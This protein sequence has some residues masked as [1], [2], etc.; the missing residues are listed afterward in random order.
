MEEILMPHEAMI[1]VAGSKVAMT[2]YHA[3][4]GVKTVANKT[5]QQDILCGYLQY[6]DLLD[7]NPRLYREG[8][9]EF[10]TPEERETAYRLAT[11]SV[12]LVGNDSIRIL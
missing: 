5:L 3:F 7:E 12:V 6:D 11:Q 1:R 8:K 10:D 4:R 2:G 9:I